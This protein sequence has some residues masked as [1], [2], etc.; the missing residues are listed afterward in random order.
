MTLQ[1]LVKLFILQKNHH[2]DTQ[3]LDHK[4]AFEDEHARLLADAEVVRED[5]MAPA[6][7]K[8]QPKIPFVLLKP[9]AADPKSP[10]P[11]IIHTHGGPGVYMDKDNPHAEIAYF[12]SQGYVVA[13]PNY[14][15]STGYPIIGDD[16]AGW[17]IWKDLSKDKHHIYGPEDVFAVAKYVQQM[18]FVDTKKIFLRGGSFGSFINSHLLVG[19]KKGLYENIFRGAHFSGGVKYPAAAAMPDDISL[20]ITHSVV[21]DIAPFA[22]ARMFMEKTL[23]KELSYEITDVKPA[24]VQTLVVHKGNHHLIDPR[25]RLGDE[26]SQ[27]YQEMVRYL[28]YTTGFIEELNAGKFFQPV[29]CYDQYKEVLRDRVTERDVSE[30]VLQRVHTYM[31]THPEQTTKA[32]S[33]KLETNTASAKL[34]TDTA[35]AKLATDTASAKSATDT[36]SAKSATDTASAKS[37]TDT[38]SAK[39]ATDTASVKSA[40]DSESAKSETDT[41]PV[42]QNTTSASMHSLSLEA[43]EEVYYG[44]TLALL[45]L[46]LGNAFTGDV[47]KDLR[48]YF[49][50]HFAPISWT[51]E[52]NK[53]NN[54]GRMIL[55]NAAFFDQ[56]VL[57]I[58]EEEAVLKENPD[59]MVMYHTAE[60]NSLQL[61]TFINL[62][63]N[64]LLGKPVTK[65]DV[66]DEMRLYDF[67]KTSFEDIDIFLHKMRS[68]DKPD[69]I[70]NNIPGFSERALACNPAL[71]SNPHSTASCSLWWYFNAKDCERVPSA[72]VIG[73]LLKILGIYSPERLD[74]YL[75]LF[76]REKN[77]LID[78]PQALLQQMFVPYDVA[79]QSAYMCQIWGEE[80]AQNDM[81]LQS[82]SVVRSLTKD[83]D[84]FEERLLR[85][86][87]AF[88]N[89]GD[90][91]GFGDTAKGFK[92]SNTLQ[93][94]YLPRKDEGVVT[95]SYFRSDKSHHDFVAKL[96]QL[97]KED[98]AD[99]LA[100]GSTIPDFILDGAEAAKKLVYN[101]GRLAFFTPKST[102]NYEAFYKQQEQL[103][104]GLVQNPRK[105][106]YGGI[107]ALDVA[108]KTKLQ[109]QLRASTGGKVSPHRVHPYSLCLYLKGYTYFDLLKEAATA[110]I[111][112]PHIGTN[113]EKYARESLDFVMKMVELFSIPSSAETVE[114]YAHNCQR[115]VEQL[116]FKV[117]THKFNAEQHSFFKSST[118][119]DYVEG[120]IWSQELTTAITP[121]L[122]YARLA[123]QK[124]YGYDIS[125]S[126]MGLY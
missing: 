97:I 55:D 77:S 9:K 58:N 95:N 52:R 64:M 126:M 71:I 31:Y 102:L 56:M 68:R 93:M 85:N 113:I 60:N 122:R 37:A 57:A 6:L 30:D 87:K 62:W 43:T 42:K 12:L 33:A 69:G 119:E 47:Q 23:L 109:T 91:E 114:L 88:T 17:K 34:A 3:N 16:A 27:S 89:F 107:T 5:V 50:Q 104:K 106:I 41:A 73:E 54:A 67:M 82:P 124:D 21:D 94:R 90:C 14:R 63:Q 18:P 117:T 20:L 99:Y 15:G 22:D 40:T 8:G 123:K 115:L 13:C 28:E 111:L 66:I 7:F 2:Q 80:F 4:K 24:S 11:L 81:A 59:H 38:A 46:Q 32:E 98:F 10:K 1:E 45:K 125:S 48:L 116:Q 105:Q 100:L 35:S 19:V 70:F 53:L 65:L 110:V 103:Y 49:Q 29:D 72:S 121:V 51:E 44:P 108:T 74:R 61:Y 75:Q 25:L 76:E 86:K 84:L 92:Y 83:P 78:S 39:S 118:G 112:Q 101:Q 26:S 120:Y 79:E 96:S 36:A